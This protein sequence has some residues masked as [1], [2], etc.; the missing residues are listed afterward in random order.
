MTPTNLYKIVYLKEE[1]VDD[2]E[3]AKAL[4]RSRLSKFR[5]LSRACIYRTNPDP[6]GSGECVATICLRTELAKE[7][8]S[9]K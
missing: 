8:K 2:L 9:H 4:A 5:D 6:A 3:Y 1:F 7:L